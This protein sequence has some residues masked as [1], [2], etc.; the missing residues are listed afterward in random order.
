MK[1]YAQLIDQQAIKAWNVLAGDSKEMFPLELLVLDAFVLAIK[2][3]AV[4]PT[5]FYIHQ[6]SDRAN[7]CIG[8]AKKLHR[9][10]PRQDFQPQ[11]E[12]LLMDLLLY[13]ATG[14]EGHGVER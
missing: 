10:Y 1:Y 6:K 12:E 2:E 14:L 9:D 7:F 4:L 3:K 8:I 11:N 13:Q 5:N